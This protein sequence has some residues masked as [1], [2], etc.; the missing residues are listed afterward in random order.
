V[1][2]ITPSGPNKTHLGQQK[3]MYLAQTYRSTKVD[4]S[5]PNWYINFCWP[6][7]LGQIHQLLLT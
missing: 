5:G 4:V 3:L 2:C 6:I 1:H 7:C